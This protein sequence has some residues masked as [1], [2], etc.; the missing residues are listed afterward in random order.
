MVF[1]WCISLLNGA[2]PCLKTGVYSPRVAFPEG[3]QGIYKG[4]F[5]GEMGRS[6]AIVFYVLKY[7]RQSSTDFHKRYSYPRA[8]TSLWNSF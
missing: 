8:S 7:L 2:D 5:I 3:G 6:V 4:G 1:Y